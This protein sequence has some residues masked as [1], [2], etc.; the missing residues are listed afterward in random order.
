MERIYELADS[1]LREMLKEP[2]RGYSI[3]TIIQVTGCAKSEVKHIC[4]NLK[5]GGYKQYSKLNN[6]R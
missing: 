1:L 2:T 6:K 5:N 3:D 4:A